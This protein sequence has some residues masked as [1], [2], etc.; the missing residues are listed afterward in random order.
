MPG[1]FLLLKL[2]F[3]IAPSPTLINSLAA[4]YTSTLI[5]LSSI[6]LTERVWFSALEVSALVFDSSYAVSLW[7]MSN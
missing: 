6:V 7:E 5:V 3:K 4:E 2:K 1:S